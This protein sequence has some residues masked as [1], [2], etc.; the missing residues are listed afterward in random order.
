[1]HL[2]FHLQAKDN[3]PEN[4]GSPTLA[5][6]LLPVKSTSVAFLTNKPILGELKELNPLFK[7]LVTSAGMKGQRKLSVNSPWGGE[8]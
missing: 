5:G 8:I 4:Q 1:M 7:R 3:P 6:K 2:L